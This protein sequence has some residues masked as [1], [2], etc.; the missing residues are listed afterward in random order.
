MK[1]ASLLL[2][3]AFTMYGAQAADWASWWRTPD[4]RG[5]ALLKAGDAKAA[6]QI[7]TDPQ[8]RAYAEFRNGQ[9]AEA[10]RDY[11]TAGTADAHYNRGNALAHGGDLPGALKAYD[12]ALAREPKHQ[13]ALH[14]RA[15][16]QKALEQQK[17]PPKQDQNENQQKKDEQKKD[18]QKKDEQKN[19]EQ[20]QDQN[21]SGEQK[22]GEQKPGQQGQPKPAP[23]PGKEGK[24]PAQPK[25][26]GD[27]KKQAEQ[28]AAQS[29]GKAA[30]EKAPAG[31]PGTQAPVDPRAEEKRVSE[32]QW[33]RAIPDD[34]G[35][36]LRR[37][38]LIEHMIRQQE[39]QR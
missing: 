11:A 2:A 30:P 1:R 9:F 29:L 37:K 35:G 18:E 24:Q 3:L 27:D 15:L 13:D 12:A 25:D 34:P 22:S 31:K 5:D 20:K 19:G 39:Q 17:Q 33:L 4:Q 14:N 26:A 10:A 7:Y 23:D 8:R 6:A 36:L 38:L 21:K 16:V 28:D 32:E